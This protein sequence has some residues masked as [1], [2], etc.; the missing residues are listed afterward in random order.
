MDAIT[1]IRQLYDY[2][3]WA[4]RRLFEVGAGLG[5]AVTRDLGAH[6]SVPT[7]KGMFTHLCAADE[8]WLARWKGTAPGRLPADADFPAMADLR[9]RWDGTEA[10]QRA[11]VDALDDAALARPVT[12]RTAAG[13]FSSPLGS[14][15]PHVV[16]HATHHR[17]ELATMITLISG[18]PPDT[19]LATYRGT[20]GRAGGPRSR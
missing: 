9:A 17:S 15:L 2:H 7:V 13:E 20:L 10:E 16:N 12:Y 6:W 18:S 4:N 8:I 19:G 11:F 3:R 1:L 5:E 14:L